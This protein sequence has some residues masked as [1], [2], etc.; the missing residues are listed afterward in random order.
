MEGYQIDF[1]DIHEYPPK[2]SV[3][4]RIKSGTT[5]LNSDAFNVNLDTLLNGVLVT[6]YGKHK[7]GDVDMNGRIEAADYELIGGEAGD[8]C[9]P[10]RDASSQI[11]KNSYIGNNLPYSAGS[12]IG[13]YYSAN[14]KRVADINGDGKITEEDYVIL[15]KFVRSNGNDDNG[16][17]LMVGKD[18]YDYEY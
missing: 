18:L 7:L 10:K 6:N 2:A 13:K 3:R 15:C 4:I 12:T 9:N 11:Y 5:E 8:N 16:T 14:E 1:Y 17:G